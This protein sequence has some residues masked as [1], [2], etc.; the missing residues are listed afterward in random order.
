MLL[1]IYD[2]D[3]DCSLKNVTK[4]PGRGMTQLGSQAYMRNLAGKN[5]LYHIIFK[6]N[7][8]LDKY[9]F[10]KMS[11]KKFIFLECNYNNLIFY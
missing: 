6:Y 8:I 2:A 4:N 7:R 10:K 5:I 9:S 11:C 1:T 3:V